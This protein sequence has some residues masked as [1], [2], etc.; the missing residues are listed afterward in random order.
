MT[1]GYAFANRAGESLHGRLVAHLADM[2]DDH[3]INILAQDATPGD[4]ALVVGAGASRV[5]GWLAETGAEV[6]A[7]DIEPG[8]IPL[9]AGVTVQQLDLTTDPMPD[10]WD[11]VTAV[12]HR[13]DGR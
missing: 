5:P 1:A 12:G 2:L 3:S 4:R 10:G 13:E 6:L 9:V 8:N 11:L 7:V